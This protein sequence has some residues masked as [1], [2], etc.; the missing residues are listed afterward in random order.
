MPIMRS[1]CGFTSPPN[2]TLFGSSA[3]FLILSVLH[4]SIV[5]AAGALYCSPTSKFL[6]PVEMEL[7]TLI[8]SILECMGHDKG[9]F[10]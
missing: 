4:E 10:A 5:T 9:K 6:D 3:S 7:R 8:E 2:S 1:D